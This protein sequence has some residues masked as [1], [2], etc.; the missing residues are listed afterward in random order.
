MRLT[1]AAWVGLV[2]AAV[3]LVA[4]PR[5][6]AAPVPKGAGKL[7][8]PTEEQMTA[9]AKNLKNILIG[10]HAYHDT[11]GSLPND[12][13]TKDG[14]PLLSWRVLILPFMEEGPL[15]QQFKLDEPWDSEHN[16]KL[17]GKMPKVYAPVRVAAKEGMTFYRVF[18]GKDALFGAGKAQNQL[19]LTTVVD[20]L[21]NTGLVFEAGEP[22]V[23]TR[24]DDLVLDQKKK[25]PPLGGMFDGVFH[26]AMGDGSVVRCKKDADEAAVKSLIT[27]AGAEVF[28]LARL[29]AK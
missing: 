28:D 7:P 10:F 20:G 4:G 3:V 25:L 1:V 19:R 17:I 26:V 21:S 8:P 11:F 5:G 29:E 27:P 16:K 13:Y 15:H 9:S 24:P 22:A 6:A 14:K 12:T 18:S 2:G 23:W